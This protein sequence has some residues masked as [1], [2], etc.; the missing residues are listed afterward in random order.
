[1]HAL[2]CGLRCATPAELISITHY[3][4]SGLSAQ[5]RHESPES[6]QRAAHLYSRVVNSRCT[7]PPKYGKCRGVDE[8]THIK[9]LSAWL[10][11]EWKRRVF[12]RVSNLPDAAVYFFCLLKI[13]NNVLEWDLWLELLE[14]C[15]KLELLLLCLFMP[16][17]PVQSANTLQASS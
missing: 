8:C 14:F 1:M 5:R 6:S 3:V 13:L 15:S 12:E 7:F 17:E 11:P 2:T 4:V 16:S 10:N 9:Y